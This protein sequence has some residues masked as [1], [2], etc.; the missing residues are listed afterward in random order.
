L[1]TRFQD[2][3]SLLDS[4]GSSIRSRWFRSGI[5]SSADR[6]KEKDQR[7][8]NRKTRSKGEVSS[9]DH[10]VYKETLIRARLH[11]LKSWGL[12]NQSCAGSRTFGP[13]GPSFGLLKKLVSKVLD[14]ANPYTNTHI[15]R[16]WKIV[17]PN[18]TS[19]HPLD[20]DSRDFLHVMLRVIENYRTLCREEL[21]CDLLP[22]SFNEDRQ[23]RWA[24]A[25]MFSYNSS[26]EYLPEN[27]YQHLV[28]LLQRQTESDCLYARLNYNREFEGHPSRERARDRSDSKPNLM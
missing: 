10:S 4:I 11:I 19:R 17:D 24:Q 13:G 16:D 7:L 23:R 3:S 5:G 6:V 8:A 22:Y 25:Y 21:I 20:A 12:L 1:T 28:E 27:R 26:L 18:Q 9:T 15:G 14:E 2:R